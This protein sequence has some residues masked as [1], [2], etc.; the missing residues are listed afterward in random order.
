[1]LDVLVHNPV[2]WSSSVMVTIVG[3]LL[4]WETFVEFAREKTPKAIIPVI[5]SMLVEMGFLSF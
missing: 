4:L 3:L 2:F 1:L 5:D